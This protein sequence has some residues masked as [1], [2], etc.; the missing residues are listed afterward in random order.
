MPSQ[1]SRD[2]PVDV[3]EKQMPDAGAGGF[4]GRADQGQKLA[5]ADIERDAAQDRRAGKALCDCCKF[6]SRHEK[7]RPSPPDRFGAQGAPAKARP[8]DPSRDA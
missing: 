1:A 7:C 2:R 4:D 8:C 5:I 3:A 6:Y